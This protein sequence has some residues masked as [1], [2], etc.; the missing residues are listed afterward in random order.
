MTKKYKILSWVGIAITIA[1]F[2]LVNVFMTMLTK[3]MP[4]K[5]D[6]TENKVYDLTAESYEYL[7]GY[8]KDTTIYIIS[9]AAGQDSSVRAVLDRYAAANPHIKITNVDTAKNPGFGREYVKDGEQL[10]RGDMVVSAGSKAK[11][12]ENSE[13]AASAS[14]GSS[15]LN[16]ETKVTSALK[17]VSSDD[18]FTAYFTTGHMEDS[19]DSAKEALGNENYISDSINLFSDDIPDDTSVVIIALPQVDFS[20]AEIAKLDAYARNGGALEV[21][22]DSECAELPNLNDYLTLNG[23]TISNSGIVEASDHIIGYQAGGDQY[24]L[25]AADYGNNEVLGKVIEKAKPVLYLPYS[26][27]L[28]MAATAGNITVEPYLTSSESSGTTTDYKSTDSRGSSNIALMST[29]SE[30]GGRIYV[31]GTPILFDAYEVSEMDLAG[32]EN[33]DYF[34]TVT[35]SMTGTGDTFVVPVKTV[36]MNT[37][38]M[39]V[40]VRQVYMFIILFLIPGIALAMGLIVFFKR[41]NM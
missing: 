25:F 30:T 41:R 29:N 16:V 38:N 24:M 32:V 7:K 5:I 28:N 13:L 8:D 1:V 12:I 23:I 11:V 19:F 21:Y 26:K 6:L 17:Y 35:N 3:K 37:M 33:V 4:V 31:S 2:V 27:A 40:A 34:V 10:D 20:T 22:V 14:D 18:V 9:S 39:T 15:G 36:S